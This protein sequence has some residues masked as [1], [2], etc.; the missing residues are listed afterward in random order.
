MTDIRDIDL[1][2][3]DRILMRGT[4]RIIEKCPD[5][6]YVYDEVSGAFFLACS[7]RETGL[8]ILDEH[9]GLNC[10]L[11]MVTDTE[12]GKIAFQRYG[13][14][15]MFECYQVAYP[16]E[17]PGFENRL[18]IREA[19]REDLPIITET[20][21]LISPEEMEKVVDRGSLLLGY[22]DGRLVG[23]IGEHLEG[24]MGMLY[25]FPEYRRKGYAEELEKAY[26]LR[27][28]EKGFIPFGQIEKNNL[29][30]LELQRK[31]GMVR[32]ENLSCWMWK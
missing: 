19:G 30:S 4:G 25:V 31:I 13:F 1:L 10:R 28:I 2:G 9:A 7:D 16:G 8:R 23:F 20:Y 6:L 17:P 22:Q 32:S 26:I 15:E 21:H 27:T 29:A 11:L 3:I 12:L 14:D 24:S 18:S 5:A